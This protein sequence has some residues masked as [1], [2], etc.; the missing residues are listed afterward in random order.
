VRSSTELWL[1][2]AGLHVAAMAVVGALVV[3]MFRSDTTGDL[4][5]PPD[6]DGDG[7]GG[8]EPRKPS[9]GPSVGGGPPLP[10]SRPARVRLREPG[11]L[12]K[13]LPRHQRRPARE[14]DRP[15]RAPTRR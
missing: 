8:I 2:T 12:A 9:R 11:R 6:D 10:R 14:P 13:L 7:R 1:F 15:R 3:M 5:R 4:R